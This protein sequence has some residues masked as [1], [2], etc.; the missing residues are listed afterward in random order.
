MP[1]NVKKVNLQ[2]QVNQFS[3]M[4]AGGFACSCYSGLGRRDANTDQN[5]LFA[6]MP[7]KTALNSGK[8]QHEIFSPCVGYSGVGYSE[9]RPNHYLVSEWVTNMRDYST[10]TT[11]SGGFKLASSSLLRVA[12]SCGKALGG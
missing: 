12:G 3:K 7:R 11:K 5:N 1:A 4:N 9:V 10:A 6:M 2:H 8:W